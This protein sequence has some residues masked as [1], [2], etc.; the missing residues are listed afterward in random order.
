MVVGN[1]AGCFCGYGSIKG[2]RFGLILIST[3]VKSRI[4][5]WGKQGS[6]ALVEV[7]N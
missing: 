6:G 2:N 5:V 3:D 1:E 7:G 4:L